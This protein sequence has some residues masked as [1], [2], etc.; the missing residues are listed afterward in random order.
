MI[1]VLL[2]GS[3]NTRSLAQGAPAV[4]EY[5][6]PTDQSKPFGITAGP[7]GAMWF[8]EGDGNKI[9]RIAMDGKVTE[10]VIPTAESLPGL[11]TTGPDGAIWVL[12]R[13]GNKMWR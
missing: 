12:E 2:L 10:F 6:I 13:D 4:T 1:V 5:S 9:G 7:D 11:L 3:A 8:A